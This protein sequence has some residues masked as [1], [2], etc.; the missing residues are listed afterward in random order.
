MKYTM[1]KYT[2]WLIILHII[3]I[4]VISE[5]QHK[6]Y[7]RNIKRFSFF[8]SSPINTLSYI[9]TAEGLDFLEE[10]LQT[11]GMTSTIAVI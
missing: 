3:T 8:L 7:K 2:D 9:T 1:S 10:A 5:H 11:T 6:F 4:I